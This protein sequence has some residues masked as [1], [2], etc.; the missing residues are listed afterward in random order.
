MVWGVVLLARSET[1]SG[2]D[3]RWLRTIY[4]LSLAGSLQSLGARCEA[5]PFA[6]TL[7]LVHPRGLGL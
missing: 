6:F 7:F 3:R 1:G 5:I 4:N 2:V